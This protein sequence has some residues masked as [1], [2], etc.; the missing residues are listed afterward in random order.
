MINSTTHAPINVVGL[1][2]KLVQAPG[3]SGDEKAAADTALA[4]MEVLGFDEVTRDSHGS[5]IGR[6]GPAD[7]QVAL[8]FDGHLDVVPAIGDWSVDPY[9]GTIK[10]GRL[11]GRGSTDMKGA[12]AAAICGVAAAAKERSLTKQVIVSASVMEEILEGV[13]LGHILDTYA[14]EAVVICEPSNLE[15][16]IGQR[17]RLEIVLTFHGKPAHASSPQLGENPIE[18][19]A[20]ALR[21]LDDI[22]YLDDPMLGKGVLVPVSIVSDPLPSPSMIP[23][24]T[25]IN[26][27]RRTVPGETRETVFEQINTQLTK[28]NIANF[29]LECYAEPATTY[30]GLALSPDRDFPSWVLP[31]AHPAAQ[32]GL[33]AI[34][35]SGLPKNYGAWACCTNGSESA[36]RR[37][38]PTIGIGP[39]DLQDAHI[40]D[41]S[42]EVSQLTKAVEVYKNLVLDLAG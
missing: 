11:F 23:I 22:V 13:A 31:I 27:D 15:L 29:S 37:G 8:L 24:L 38:I 26:F 30:T 9:G 10:D 5:V 34:A 7:A 2:Q 12:V 25:T 17:G 33:R 20:R 32:A 36:G 19:A 39:G 18:F 4:A 14:P 41:E 21:H 40:I 16:R 1:T 3:G 35:A 42:I 6:A 28:N